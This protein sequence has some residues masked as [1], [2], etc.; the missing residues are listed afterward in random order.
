MKWSPL[1]LIAA[2]ICAATTFASGAEAG[3]RI[4]LGFG[5][6]LPAFTAHGNSYHGAREYH[7]KRYVARHHAKKPKVHVAKKKSAEPKVAKKQ[8]QEKVAAKPATKKAL[9][10]AK[11][12]AQVSAP[13]DT[14]NSS[15]TTASLE[16]GE[17]TADIDN[18]ESI[19][20][21]IPEPKPAIK[22]G[23]Q[24][25]KLDCKKFFPSVGMTLTVPCE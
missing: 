22:P 1:A 10:V 14:E 18:T 15:I 20:V 7:R 11:A 6:P 23:K 17:P 12:P 2:I 25:S 9:A 16:A 3:F 13:A 4:R 19:D 8:Q 5:G 21:Q 24:A